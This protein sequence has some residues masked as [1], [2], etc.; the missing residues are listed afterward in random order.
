MSYQYSFLEK[1]QIS[2]KSKHGHFPQV[3]LKQWALD[4]H[5]LKS[6]IHL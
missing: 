3:D 1:S 2:H 6:T 4:F 5:R